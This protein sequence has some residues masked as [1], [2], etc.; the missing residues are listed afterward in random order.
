MGSCH[1]G[2]HS[3]I[4]QF[5]LF[6]LLAHSK[7]RSEDQSLQN[8]CFPPKGK[9]T[10]LVPQLNLSQV[11]VSGDAGYEGGNLA[12]F[13]YSLR[14]EKKER[15]QLTKCVSPRSVQEKLTLTIFLYCPFPASK[16]P[17]HCC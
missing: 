5:L 10:G 12:G 2:L 8:G 7:R 13:S 4:C 14:R 11:V 9:P 3:D 1:R 15:R 16:H 6:A 17:S